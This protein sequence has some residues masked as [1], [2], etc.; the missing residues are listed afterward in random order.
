MQL[1]DNSNQYLLTAAQGYNAPMTLG[2]GFA[3]SNG[4]KASLLGIPVY[5]STQI[6]INR[7][8][9]SSTD[10][11]NVYLLDSSKAVLLE[12]QGIELAF[13][14][15]VGFATDQSAYRAIA[16]HGIAAVQPTAVEK[17]TGVRV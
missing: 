9:G 3:A 11:T 17:I 10:T 13:S 15:Q 12:R 1:K 5:V 16:R 14:D 4:P 8:T 6:A 7:T 2:G